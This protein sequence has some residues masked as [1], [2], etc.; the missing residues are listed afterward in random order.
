MGLKVLDLLHGI[1]IV[2]AQSHIVRG[3]N[4][5]LFARD[6]FGAADGKLGHLKGFDVRA[7]FVVPD[8]DVAGVEGGEGP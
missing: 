5:P 3:G 4:E 6:E 2:N 8:G 1:V 7:G